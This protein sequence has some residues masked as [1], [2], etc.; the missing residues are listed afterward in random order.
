[1]EVGK[2]TIAPGETK[3][4]SHNTSVNYIHV[5]AT[6]KFLVIDSD[7]LTPVI[8]PILIQEKPSAE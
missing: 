8:T 1:M 5:R 2:I 6:V 3:S 7:T 4:F